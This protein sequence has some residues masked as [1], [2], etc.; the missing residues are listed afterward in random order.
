MIKQVMKL[1]VTTD[2]EALD[3]DTALHSPIFKVEALPSPEFAELLENNGFTRRGR[4]SWSLPNDASNRGKRVLNVASQ[5]MPTFFSFNK[6]YYRYNGYGFITNHRDQGDAIPGIE[7][8]YRE[9]MQEAGDERIARSASAAKSWSDWTDKL[10]EE[11]GGDI[12]AVPRMLSL[13]FVTFE[14]AEG[15]TIWVRVWTSQDSEWEQHAA[16]FIS[17]ATVSR[18]EIKY[19]QF[20]IGQKRYGIAASNGWVGS[21]INAT[22]VNSVI[23]SF[24]NDDTALYFENRA[25]FGYSKTP[26]EYF[27]I[28]EDVQKVLDASNNGVTVSYIHGRPSAAS[29]TIGK[30]FDNKNLGL[31]PATVARMDK[32]TKNEITANMAAKI[33]NLN[34]P[35]VNVHPGVTDI[36]KMATAKPYKDDNRLRDYQQEAVGLHLSTDLGYLLACSPGLGKTVI[37]LSAMRARAKSIEKYR[38]L[39]VVEGNVREQWA[40]E[41]S[42]WFPEAKVVTLVGAKQVQELRDALDSDDPVLVVAGYAQMTNVYKDMAALDEYR[43]SIRTAIR[44]RRKPQ[45]AIKPPAEGIGTLLLN[46]YWN[47]VSADEALVIVNS[48]S[49][50]NTAMWRIRQNSGVATVLTGTPVDKGVDDLAKYISWVRNDKNMFRG[51]KLSTQFDV[52]KLD[53]E[54]G[55]K[56]LM[57]A[58]GSLIFRRDISVVAEELPTAHDPKV[59]RL[60]PTAAEKALA[61][62]A[63]FELRRAHTELV[64]AL[65][66]RAAADESADADQ[67]RETAALL[68][69]AR[70]AWLGG[71]QLAR[72][73]CSDPYAL[74]G[75]ESTGAALLA[76]QGLIQAATIAPSTKRAKLVE[77]VSEKVAERKQILVFT[78]FSSVAKILVSD[79]QASGINAKA[80]VGGGGA[81]RD[82][83]RV[84]FQNGDLDVLVCTSAGKRGV[85]LN[86]AGVVIH[87]DLPWTPKDIVQ[88]TGRSIRLGSTIDNVE[89]VFMILNDTIEEKIS[90]V[91]V[92]RSM[93]A[94]QVLDRTRGADIT[95]TE[96]GMALAGLIKDAGKSR[97]NDEVMEFA[98]LLNGK[99]TA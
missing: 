41:A 10:I 93:E 6:P 43:E 55:A 76:S 80:F 98:A 15:G 64:D 97:M 25:Y 36:I 38:G 54:T 57:N 39:V 11:W 59:Y 52:S 74:L 44:N 88:R 86:K 42:I 63:E 34:L 3:W 91:V 61:R 29:V 33:A 85:T 16:N 2:A 28:S 73:A 95:Q 92:T 77:V 70:A 19:R 22:D 89:I 8:G 99:L 4:F 35:F 60:E 82:R 14:V 48:A 94:L 65:E 87:Y 32:G 20:T 51:V 62:G 31:L 78:E 79:L 26:L 67:A 90:N 53:T 68:R 72:L 24:T 17:L 69:Q 83:N 9:M 47:D 45:G 81:A 18:G 66:A 58:I 1:T 12:H 7:R 75:S 96:T 13:G 56:A 5:L 50:Q 40:E 27:E 21:P 49:K 30:G 71:T 37:Q 46:Q 84:E 23:D